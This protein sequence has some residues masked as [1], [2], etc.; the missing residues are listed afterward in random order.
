MIKK[1][2]RILAV[3]VVVLIVLAGI[4]YQGFYGPPQIKIIN[5][6]KAELT[7]VA[8]SGVGMVSAHF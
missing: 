5:Q 2:L 8:L 7:N 6:S 4:A 3:V 1:G